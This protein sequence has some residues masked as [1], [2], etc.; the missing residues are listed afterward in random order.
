MS[1]RPPPP[2]RPATPT[3]GPW[4]WTRSPSG[5]HL[6]SGEAGGWRAILHTD[7]ADTPRPADR[8]II[9]RAPEI[10]ALEERLRRVEEER[11]EAREVL[12]AVATAMRRAA[13]RDGD[14]CLLGIPSIWAFLAHPAV[15]AA[16]DAARAASPHGG[17]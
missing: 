9:A 15:V 16:V 2:E 4:R 10:P 3:P 17:A 13:E 5:W 7:T 1:P 8:D 6:E 14:A 12:R 11:D